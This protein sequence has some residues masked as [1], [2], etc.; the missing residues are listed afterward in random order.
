MAAA[1]VIYL[2]N[3]LQSGG[4]FNTAVMRVFRKTEGT[5]TA[6]YILSTDKSPPHKQDVFERGTLTQEVKILQMTEFA[7][8]F[9]LIANNQL[10]VQRTVSIL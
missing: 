3:W 8:S 1:E 7:I 4:Q 5:S 2:G 9:S 10:T 6:M